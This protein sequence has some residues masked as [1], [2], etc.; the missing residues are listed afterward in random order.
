MDSLTTM[1]PR[2]LSPS[3]EVDEDISVGQGLAGHDCWEQ[4]ARKPVLEL[5][6]PTKYACALDSG[7]GDGDYRF[8]KLALRE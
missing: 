4:W 8:P 2:N 6:L 5:R 1:H 3:R 7:E